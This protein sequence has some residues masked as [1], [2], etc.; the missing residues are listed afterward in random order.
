MKQDT[1]NPKVDKLIEDT[2][3]HLLDLNICL[4]KAVKEEAY[5]YAATLR[6]SITM[7]INNY[8]ISLATASQL[9]YVEWLS[10]ITAQNEYIHDEINK[11]IEERYKL[12]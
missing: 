9:N 11:K 10:K 1:L 3:E 5:E 4:I 7:V 12:F 8:S 6:D 2:C